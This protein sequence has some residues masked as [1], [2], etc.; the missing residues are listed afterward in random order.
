MKLK[1]ATRNPHV[2]SVCPKARNPHVV[3]D[4]QPSNPP[5]PEPAGT[6]TH[7]PRIRHQRRVNFKLEEGVKR[8]VATEGIELESVS[9]M[10]TTSGP[11]AHHPVVHVTRTADE[12]CRTVSCTLALVL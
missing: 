1:A 7:Y 11:L 9:V 6:N 10:V 12:K 2:V 5:G 8:S 3:S 4:C